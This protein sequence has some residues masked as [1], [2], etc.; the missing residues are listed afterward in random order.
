MVRYNY[1]VLQ[2]IKLVT[3]NYGI[4][5]NVLSIKEK[6]CTSIS[7][8][9]L[10]LRFIGF[11]HSS[12]LILSLFSS[13]SPGLLILLSWSSQIFSSRSLNIMIIFFQVVMICE[14]A[15]SF[16]CHVTMW[17]GIQRYVHR[18]TWRRSCSITSLYPGMHTSAHDYG[19]SHLI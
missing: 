1:Y 10:S 3:F 14:V 19:C 9:I 11:S 13:C 6:M 18:D 2:I 16:F 7:L 5:P 15:M 8:I 17:C 4:I 12:H